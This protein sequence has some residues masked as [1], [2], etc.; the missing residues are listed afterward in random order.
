MWKATITVVMVTIGIL[1]VVLTTTIVLIDAAT[2]DVAAMRDRPQTGQ[3]QRGNE[4][5]HP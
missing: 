1:A 2:I 5:A 3:C 4:R